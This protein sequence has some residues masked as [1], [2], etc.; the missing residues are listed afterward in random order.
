MRRRHSSHALVQRT[1][2][3]WRLCVSAAPGEHALDH[4]R[5]IR[6]R[7]SAVLRFNAEHVKAPTLAV[8][9][10]SVSR[11]VACAAVHVGPAADLCLCSDP[12]CGC[13]TH[14]SIG[15]N[16][17]VLHEAATRRGYSLPRGAL[18][19]CAEQNAISSMLASG[20]PLDALRALV[21]VT[22]LH[23]VD[24]DACAATNAPFDSCVV[25][26]PCNPCRH[27]ISVAA[28]AVRH[29]RPGQRVYLA[30]AVEAAVRQ[31]RDS[32]AAACGWTCPEGVERVFLGP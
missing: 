5:S 8:A 11:R 28:L 10:R 14:V 26:M 3:A 31:Y 6:G 25:G 21:V 20:V 22:Q 29:R 24:G 4:L 17:A 12:L 27:I 15:L 13:A 19:G 1:A 18:K 23:S 16:H 2:G 32:D 9:N 7:L 30:A